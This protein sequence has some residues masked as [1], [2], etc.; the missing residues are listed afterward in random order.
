M[1]LYDLE[2]SAQS[3]LVSRNAPNKKKDSWVKKDDAPPVF[4]VEINDRKKK[5][6]KDFSEF[7]FN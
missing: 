4:D 3:D 5:K 1:K 7:T 6:K 2:E